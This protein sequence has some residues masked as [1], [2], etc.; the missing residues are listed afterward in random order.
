MPSRARQVRRGRAASMREPEPNTFDEL[1]AP[2]TE[3]PPA[4]SRPQSA[5]IA[6]SPAS[7]SFKPYQRVAVREVPHRFA[8]VSLTLRAAVAAHAVHGRVGRPLAGHA[9]AA[10]LRRP[11]ARHRPPTLPRPQ[12]QRARRAARHFCRALPKL[13]AAIAQCTQ[14]VEMDDDV[15]HLV[16]P[17][18]EHG[19]AANL[20]Y[21]L[22]HAI[23]RHLVGPL[24]V[25]AWLTRAVGDRRAVDRRV[26]PDQL[27]GARDRLPRP[28]SESRRRILR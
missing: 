22:M 4:A 16:T 23:C 14:A 12:A 20:T 2:A 6:A 13:R 1:P 27:A 17:T 8:R 9:A 19:A 21:K 10:A 11:C 18:N 26:H 3:P 5:A 7:G 28:R 15:T 25:T 24:G